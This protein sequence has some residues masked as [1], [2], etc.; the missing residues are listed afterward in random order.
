VTRVFTVIIRDCDDP[1][2][3][4]APTISLAVAEALRVVN[5][6]PAPGHRGIEDVLSAALVI[7]DLRV[8]QDRRGE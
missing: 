6:P 8:V 7:E 5:A 1:I 4:A 3:V 2:H